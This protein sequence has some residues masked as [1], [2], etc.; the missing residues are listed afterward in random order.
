MWLVVFWA[1]EVVCLWGKTCEASCAQ[2]WA[3]AG[4]AGVAV[5]WWAGFCSLLVCASTAGSSGS[6]Q[7]F[8]PL[9][10]LGLR[11]VPRAVETPLAIRGLCPPGRFRATV[12]GKQSPG[13]RGGRSLTV[14]AGM[15]ASET[16]GGSY[17]KQPEIAWCG[18]W[19]SASHRAGDEQIKESVK[20]II[21]AK[22]DL[23][24]I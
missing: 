9:Q 14:A 15:L 12:G 7:M 22:G 6:L 16:G 20:G 18:D 24:C 4:Q 23:G 3:E 13:W 21:V 2:G 19:S 10:P 17:S 8:K 1:T 11:N 5:C